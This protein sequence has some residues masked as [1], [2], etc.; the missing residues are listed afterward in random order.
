MKEL[1]G[2]LLKYN[3]QTNAEMI[4]ILEKLSAEQ[5]TGDARSFYGSVLGLLNH[6]LVS[7]VM[8]LN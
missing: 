5:V 8:W 7:D 6:I 2:L 4:G 1:F 3:A